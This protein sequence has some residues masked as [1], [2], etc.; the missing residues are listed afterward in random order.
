MLVERIGSGIEGLDGGRLLIINTI[1]NLLSGSK[2][3]V[4]KVNLQRA[5]A[6]VIYKKL[7]VTGQVTKEMDVGV[8]L[9]VINKT[10]DIV[11]EK[12]NIDA[13]IMKNAL[14]ENDKISFDIDWFHLTADIDT[15]YPRLTITDNETLRYFIKY[16]ASFL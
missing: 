1:N 3:M 11:R 2:A 16:T 12:I 7:I 10:L 9:A 6:V 8:R 5:F 4:E 15:I 13:D 14:M